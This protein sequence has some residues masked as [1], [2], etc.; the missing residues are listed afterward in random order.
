MLNLESLSV[1][2][3]DI[4]ISGMILSLT[5]FET[6]KGNIKGSFWIQDNINFYD[7]LI[8]HVTPYIAIDFIYAGV[9][10]N[11][12]YQC[13]G[14][15]EMTITKMGKKYIVHFVALQTAD[16][17]LTMINESYSGMSHH[18]IQSIYRESVDIGQSLLIDS[19]AITK[20]R[21][22]VPHIKAGEAI[23]NVL[24]C[25]YD[26]NSSAFCLYQRMFDQGAAR[27]T[28][29]QDMSKNYFFKN[30]TQPFEL[31]NDAID[32]ESSATST[33][34]SSDEFKLEAFQKGFISKISAGVYGNKINQI[35]LDE[36]ETVK[37][38]SIAATN[39]EI[40]KFRLSS[41]LYDNNVKS[42]FSTAEDPVAHASR[43]ERTRA[44]SQ[45]FRV[46]NTVAVPRLGCGFAVVVKVGGSNQSK[47]RQDT[48]YVI[49]NINHKFIIDDG[50]FK[51]AQDIGLIRA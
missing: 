25:A 6:I 26:V 9:S 12:V 35:G 37:F 34:G 7:N 17:N 42:I 13:D 46:N 36:T 47:S 44:Y 11:N 3:A 38:K 29:L 16:L 5:V 20:G 27:L 30:A 31:T 51:Y 40:T 39:N 8:T 41:K 50:S 15:T 28:T 18:I 19:A 48:E 14:I 43:H 21:Y 4:D 10:C 32:Q 45:M 2:I 23:G 49:A 24:S 33:I 22:N 1:K